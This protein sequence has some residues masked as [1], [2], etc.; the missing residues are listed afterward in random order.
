MKLVG[1][2]WGF[3]RKPFVRNAVLTGILASIIAIA[4]L[5][6]GIYLLYTY[7]PEVVTV[8]TWEVLAITA[9]SVLLFGIIITFFCTFFSINKYLKMNSRELYYI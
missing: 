5:A 6:G 7:E 8:I 9:G 2:S 3:I 4:V 1:A